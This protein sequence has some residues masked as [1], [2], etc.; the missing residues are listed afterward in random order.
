MK[1]YAIA[2]LLL[3]IVCFTY[4]NDRSDLPALTYWGGALGTTVSADGFADI[5]LSD[6]PSYG[7]GSTEGRVLL[8]LEKANGTGPAVGLEAG[9]SLNLLPGLNGD[10]VIQ[11]AISANSATLFGGFIGASYALIDKPV[12]RLGLSGRIGYQFINI[13]LGKVKMMPGKTAPVITAIGTFYVDDEISGSIGGVAVQPGLFAEYKVSNAFW[14]YS[15]LSW[16]Q[17]FMDSLEIKV[18]RP[19]SE[20]SSKPITISQESRYL[21]K[22]DG[23]S[24]Q[25]GIRP[26][27]NSIGPVISIGLRFTM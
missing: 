15:N 16:N 6:W 25:A 18:S 11:G 7:L 17:S 13:G 9:C 5:C 19:D 24:T 21:V 3:M 2:F 4:S 12:F 10:L 26:E 1:R 20:S 8:E 23:S 27:G 14:L 22:N